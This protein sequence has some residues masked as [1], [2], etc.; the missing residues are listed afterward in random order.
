M[1]AP[2]HTFVLW[3]LNIALLIYCWWKMRPPRKRRKLREIAKAKFR[4]MAVR[5]PRPLAPTPVGT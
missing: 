2:A 1:G 5:I 4:K 3:Y